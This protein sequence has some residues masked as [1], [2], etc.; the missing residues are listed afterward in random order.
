[1]HQDFGPR[2]SG[3][4]SKMVLDVARGLL[5]GHRILVVCHSVQAAGALCTRLKEVLNALSANN[6]ESHT[7]AKLVYAPTGGAVIFTDPTRLD[8]ATRG[9]TYD[10]FFSDPGKLEAHELAVILPCIHGPQPV[11]CHRF[12]TEYQA[13]FE[14]ETTEEPDRAA[15]RILASR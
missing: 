3:R 11:D 14:F 4:T 1:M 10:S 13:V 15:R 9:M 6:I 2:M 7:F 5:N 8:H 12:E